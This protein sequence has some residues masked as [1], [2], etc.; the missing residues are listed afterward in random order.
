MHWST[1]TTDNPFSERLFNYVE[2]DMLTELLDFF[3][4]QQSNC[5]VVPMRDTRGLTLLSF[6]A[7]HNNLTAMK[8]VYEHV[9]LNEIGDDELGHML[10]WANHRSNR[11]FTAIHFAAYHGNIVMIKYLQTEMQADV[12]CENSQGLNVLHCGAQGDKPQSIVYFVREKKMDISKQD[13]KGR[14]PLHW[15][16]FCRS[17]LT[18]EF[19]LAHP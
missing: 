1:P 19:V 12:N 7:M 4:M 15:I 3:E 10:N 18:L 11:G 16:I 2:K 13:K 6:C 9:R 17:Y 8:I 5:R 14:T